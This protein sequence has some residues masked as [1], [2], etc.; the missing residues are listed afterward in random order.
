MTADRVLLTGATGFV[1]GALYPHL[2]HAGYEIRG[3][4]RD[5]ERA[6]RHM[7]DRDFVHYEALDPVATRNAMSGCRVA[8]YLVHGMGEQPAGAEGVPEEDYEER[9]RRAATIFVAAAERAD[10]ERIVYLGGIPP[11]GEASKH[12]RS[13]LNTGEILRG[14]AVSCIELRAS[15]IVGS[16]SAS[17]QIVRDLATRLPVMVLPQW[18]KSQSEPVW[19]DDVAAALEAAAS[20]D[21]WD[22][23]HFVVPGPDRLSAREILRTVARLQSMDPVMIDVPLVTPALSSHWIS[24]VTRADE[25]LAAEL[26]EGLTSDI[27][28][29]P[30]D[31][32][33]WSRMAHQPIP[34]GE[35]VRRTLATED[36][37]DRSLSTR[38][39]ERAARAITRR[40]S[41]EQPP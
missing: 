38:L 27:V 3:G 41:D 2:R 36:E 4:T 5:P 28:S 10:V 7:P 19:I 1:G 34:F 35:A 15:M 25:A 39:V 8:Y 20:D 32:P 37:T 33:Y 17:W 16:G 31:T 24:L 13:R 14:G 11:R 9:E 23:R 40:P 21:L 22:S 26:V 6:A 30:E 12:L 18:L 29:G